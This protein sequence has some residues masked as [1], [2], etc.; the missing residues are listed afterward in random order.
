V[1]AYAGYKETLL[2]INELYEQLKSIRNMAKHDGIGIGALTA[3]YRDDWT[4][5]RLI[6]A[7]LNKIHLCIEYF[8][9]TESSV[10]NEFE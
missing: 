2:N 8:D 7:N 6:S 5:V 3:D 9:L 1:N 4:K 10:S